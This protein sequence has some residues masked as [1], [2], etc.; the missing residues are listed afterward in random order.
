VRR[1]KIAAAKLGKKRP[2]SVGRAVARAK[3]GKSLP[4][5]TKKKMSVA[6][7][8]RGTVPPAAGRVW[9]AEEEALLGKVPDEVVAE[10]TG[11]GVSAVVARR[12]LFRVDGP[13]TSDDGHLLTG[14]E[15]V[16][17]SRNPQKRRKKP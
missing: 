8:K 7:K 9:T 17:P 11:R 10:R 1:R 12:H 5:E 16:P 4:E 14:A 15:G 3:K 6:H 13:T 2:G